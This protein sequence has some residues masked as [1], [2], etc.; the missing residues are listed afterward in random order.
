MWLWVPYM[1]TL[2]MILLVVGYAVSVWS[3][4]R[5]EH[6]E[7]RPLGLHR[8]GAAARRRLRRYRRLGVAR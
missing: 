5:Q 3:L 8:R 4:K 7:E 1:A 6:F 2:L